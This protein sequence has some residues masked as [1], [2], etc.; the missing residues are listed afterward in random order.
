[1]PSQWS[2]LEIILDWNIHPTEYYIK[3]CLPTSKTRQTLS[4]KTNFKQGCKR[5]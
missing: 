1:M 3:H 2:E 5:K 4:Q